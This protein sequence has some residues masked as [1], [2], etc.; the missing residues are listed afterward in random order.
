LLYPTAANADGT[1]TYVWLFDPFIE[2]AGCSIRNLL[3]KMYEEEKAAE[4]FHLWVDAHASE[5]VEHILMQT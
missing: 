3:R 4:Y 5:Q 2:G 1:Y